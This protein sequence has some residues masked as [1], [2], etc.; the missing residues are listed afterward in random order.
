MLSLHDIPDGRL[1]APVEFHEAYYAPHQGPSWPD[2][3]GINILGT[4]LG[5]PALLKLYVQGKLEKHTLLLNFP[6]G[7]GQDG[8]L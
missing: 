5:S 2:N 4:P 1:P 7:R 6:H 8:L 3:D